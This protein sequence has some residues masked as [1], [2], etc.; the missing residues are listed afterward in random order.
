MAKPVHQLR[1]PRAFCSQCNYDLRGLVGLDGARCP[2]CGV[3][4]PF[5]ALRFREPA[6]RADLALIM[7]WTLAPAAI[8]IVMHLLAQQVAYGPS[9]YFTIGGLGLLGWLIASGVALPGWRL[10]WRLL[11]GVPVV[12]VLMLDLI[13]FAI[14]LALTLSTL[15]GLRAARWRRRR[16][17]EL[18]RKAAL[19]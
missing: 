18:A 16:R 12:A 15:T 17:A 14:G 7:F 4:L 5:D 6:R 19:A 3:K 9:E 11:L 2:E 1:P 13:G 10:R 8:V